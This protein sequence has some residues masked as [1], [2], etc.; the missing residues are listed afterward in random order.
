M[1]NASLHLDA[2]ALCRA[3]LCAW[4]R[5]APSRPLRRSERVALW[6]AR[7]IDASPSPATKGATP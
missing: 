7:I 4:S 5:P 6:V 1:P 2:L 3:L